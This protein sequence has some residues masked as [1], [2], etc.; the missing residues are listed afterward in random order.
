MAR[1]ENN[2]EQQFASIK[3]D[4]QSGKI[5]PFYLLFGKEHYYIDK[6]CDLLMEKALLPEERDFGQIVLY[7]ADVTTQ[8]IMP[9][10]IQ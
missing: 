10:N 1:I 8:Q 6:V 4:I 2:T 3:A 7:G 5:S 9:G